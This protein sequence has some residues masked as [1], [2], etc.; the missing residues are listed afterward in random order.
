MTVKL[1]LL[2]GCIRICAFQVEPPL[3]LLRF[4]IIFLFLLL[5]VLHWRISF[6]CFCS[7]SECFLKHTLLDFFLLLFNPLFDLF[8]PSTLISR[9]L[10]LVFLLTMHG[11]HSLSETAIRRSWLLFK[12]LSS[13]SELASGFGLPV[14]LS[15]KGGQEDP[16]L[17]AH[18]GVRL[19]RHK[20]QQV[21]D[22]TVDPVL[23]DLV[24][25]ER[26]K[27]AQNEERHQTHCQGFRGFQEESQA[28]AHRTHD[29][30]DA[31]HVE[32]VQHLNLQLPNQ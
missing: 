22:R 5:L 29:G 21:V 28:E 4:L 31:I 27:G 1:T 2:S 6:Y 10:S 12:Q 19:A 8:S 17:L 11:L 30:R 3:F 32:S 25:V 15:L 20:G 13:L 7:I 23:T 18:L 14:K 16:G 24:V 9:P 26:G